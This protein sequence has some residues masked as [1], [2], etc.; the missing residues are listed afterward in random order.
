[1]EPLARSPSK[2]VAQIAIAGSAI[3]GL[4]IL[5]MLSIRNAD[6]TRIVD[7]GRLPEVLQTR[8]QALAPVAPPDLLRETLEPELDPAET[9][10]EA[11][12]FDGRVL[13]AGSNAAV[14]DATVRL[15]YWPGTKVVRQ[16]SDAWLEAITGVDGSFSLALAGDDWTAGRLHNLQVLEGGRSIAFSGAVALR[17][18]VTIHVT[19][20]CALRGRCTLDGRAPSAV[21]PDI[22]D[23]KMFVHARLPIPW[24]RPDELKGTQL[25]HGEVHADGSFELPVYVA[26]TTD[27]IELAFSFNRL[28]FVTVVPLAD[29]VSEPRP[30]VELRVREV[31]FLVQTLDG[32]PVPG[33]RVAAA[34]PGSQFPSV[35]ATDSAGRTSLLL[36]EGDVSILAWAPDFTSVVRQLDPVMSRSEVRCTLRRLTDEDTI[37][38]RVLDAQDEPIRGALVVARPADLP[39]DVAMLSGESTETDAA[40]EFVLRTS[41]GDSPLLIRAFSRPLLMPEVRVVPGEHSVVFRPFRAANARIAVSSR[42]YGLPFQSGRLRYHCWHRGTSEARDGSGLPPLSVRGLLEGSHNVYVLT[43]DGS[44]FGRTTLDIVAGE[45][46]SVEIELVPAVWIE[47]RLVDRDG[48]AVTDATVRAQDEGWPP[49]AWLGLSK[50]DAAGRFRVFSAD[51]TERRATVSVDGRASGSVLLRTDQDCYVLSR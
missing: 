1:M 26:P 24:Q 44:M 30:V 39:E 34:L 23:N 45:D 41:A 40:G 46:T 16:A 6:P 2:R 49:D 27:R 3:V 29:L 9:M 35:S 43:A 25:G 13:R 10:P 5:A 7:S 22:G 28:T 38:G 20:P 32:K 14:R 19:D 18:G 31:P 12:Q 37:R 8:S 42:D 47:G 4:C 48:R 36:P 11:L 15:F 33:A 21:F 17:R 50:T 51:A